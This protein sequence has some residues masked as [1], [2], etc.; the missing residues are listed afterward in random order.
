M[1]RHGSI[2]HLQEIMGGGVDVDVTGE[3]LNQ[4]KDSLPR[5]AT[6]VAE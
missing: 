1:H 2:T 4:R 5:E 6:K 3:K